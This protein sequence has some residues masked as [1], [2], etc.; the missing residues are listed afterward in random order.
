MSNY[1]YE[2]FAKLKETKGMKDTRNMLQRKALISELKR[3]GEKVPK[4]Y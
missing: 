2:L 1:K 3:I 4:G